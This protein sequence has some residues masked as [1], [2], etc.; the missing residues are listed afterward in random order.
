MVL[1]DVED[2]D[3]E[4]ERVMADRAVRLNEVGCEPSGRG[5]HIKDDV[6]TPAIIRKDTDGDA[7]LVHFLSEQL[8]IE[9]VLA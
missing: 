1:L 6:E 8:P 2:V 3:I 9:Q 7:Q 5:S 4:V